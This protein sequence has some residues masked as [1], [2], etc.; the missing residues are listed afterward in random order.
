[1]RALRRPFLLCS[2][3]VVSLMWDNNQSAK[4]ETPR[5]Q[6]SA[7]Y[8]NGA[9]TARKHVETARA[10]LSNAIPEE[11]AIAEQELVSA[12]RVCR[13]CPDAY[14]ELGR[15]WLTDYSLGRAGLS[16]LQRAASMAEISKDLEPTRPAGDYLAAEIL[17]TIGRQAEA[18]RLYTNARQL[19]PEH[20]ETLAFDT[21]LWADVDPA[22]ALKSAQKAIAQG[23]PIQELSPWIGNALLKSTSEEKSGDALQKFAEVYPD[24]WLWHRAAMAYAGQKNWFSARIAFQRAIDLGNTL[25]SPLQLAIFEYKDMNLAKQGAKRLTELLDVIRKNKTLS[26]DSRALVESH[27]AFAHLAAQNPTVAKIHADRALGLSL[28][29]QTRVSQIVEFFRDSNQLGLLRDSL[30]RVIAGN[31]LLE[32]AHLALA[33]ISSQRK[34]YSSALDHLTSAIALAPNKDEL[35][36]ARGYAAYLATKYEAALQDF[37]VAIKQR[38][39]H[40]PYHYNR[41]CLLSLLGRNSEAF[42]SLKN[43]VLMN[44]A[45][46]QQAETDSDLDN[47]KSD[48]EFALR[49]VEIGIPLQMVSAKKNTQPEASSTPAQ[50]G[51]SPMQRVR[52]DK[53]N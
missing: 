28:N 26:T 19:Y 6:P 7:G 49:L 17:F 48:K 41:A 3:G 39:E 47:L 24:R 32:E 44:E 38:P 46:R 21:R 52:P 15:L 31:P 10:L 14:V 22:R 9:E 51:T 5:Q 2:L 34:D 1:M 8:E 18:L 43:A 23:Y 29:N 53:E 37:D 30:E 40:A 25:E 11:R 4:A 50:S 33:M 35:Y 12:T 20:V 27:A 16:A 42:D 45:L 13:T 36:S